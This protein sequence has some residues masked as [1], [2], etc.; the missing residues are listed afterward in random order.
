MSFMNFYSFKSNSTI[1]FNKQ[2][3]KMI[4]FKNQKVDPLSLTVKAS[5]SGAFT[6]SVLQHS[7]TKKRKLIDIEKLKDHSSDRLRQISANEDKN[8]YTAKNQP[9]IFKNATNQNLRGR[10]SLQDLRS[11]SYQNT[12]LKNASTSMYGSQYAINDLTER[13]TG[14]SQDMVKTP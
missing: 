4:N 12:P 3:N 5:K 7:Y 6:S 11:S 2:L 13:Q 8:I 1:S 10:F 9:N 14:S